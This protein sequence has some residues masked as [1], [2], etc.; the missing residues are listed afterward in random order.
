M[1]NYKLSWQAY[2]R[3]VVGNVGIGLFALQPLLKVINEYRRQCSLPPYSIFDDIWSKLAQLSQKPAEF[4]FPRR[5][6]PQYFHFTG[7]FFRS[8]TRTPVAFPYE[9]LTGQPIIYAS[10]GTIQNY[11][12]WI[13]HSIA[14]ACAETDAQLVITLGK[15]EDL[16]SLPRMLGNPL[17]VRYAPQLE[18]L[19]KATL[20]I[21]HAGMNTVLESLSNGVPMVA[22]PLASE[23]P[24][25]AARITWTG[26]GEVVPLSRFSVPRLRAAIHQVLTANSYRKNAYRLQEAIRQAGGVSRAADI[27]LLA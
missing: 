14:E 8:F 4:E 21:T 23:Q 3:N 5:S 19:Q 17:V 6:L 15:S 26:T 2:L 1:W 10:L 18:L 9:Q 16:E 22:I 20:T 11:Q 27:R 25:I 24:G 13:F 7:P 12:K